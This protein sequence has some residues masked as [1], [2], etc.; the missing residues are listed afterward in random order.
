MGSQWRIFGRAIASATGLWLLCAG[1]L[2]QVTGPQTLREA[3]EQARSQASAT[4]GG[5]LFDRPVYLQ[6]SQSSE[7][8]QGDIHAVL[9]H[10]FS[11]V[12]QTLGTAPAWC[13]ILILHLNVKFCRATRTGQQERLDV[14]LG[15]KFDQPLSDVH[16]LKFV[17]QARPAREDFLQLTLQAPSGP[18]GTRDYR[19]SVEAMP[20]NA[21]QT[22]LHLRYSYG[23]GLSARW[24]MQAYLATLGRDKVGF[25]KSAHGGGGQPQPVGGLRGVL[26]RNT[27]R[28]YLAI[29]SFLGAQALPPGEQMQRSLEDW[30][31]ATEGYPQQL[32]EVDR[33]AYLKMKREEVSRQERELPPGRE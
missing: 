27:V 17:Y 11:L 30:F 21:G 7:Q 8:L 6:S 32:H 12:Q 13:R 9:D 22:L 1:V 33:S 15:R 24:A 25:S 16:W 10:R 31:S 4:G 23:F 18:L 3:F 28:Y 26:E 20:L 19:I 5:S 29:E 2:A 14:G